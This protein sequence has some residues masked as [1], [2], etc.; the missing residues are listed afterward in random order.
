MVVG[1]FIMFPAAAVMGAEGDAS[2]IQ[3]AL[4]DFA[5]AFGNVV[6]SAWA[7]AALAVGLRQMTDKG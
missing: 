3:M 5:V 1:F 6:S 4:V 7:Y 2:P